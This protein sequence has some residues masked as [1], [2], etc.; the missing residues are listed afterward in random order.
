MFKALSQGFGLA[1]A[2]IVLKLFL[3]E[4]FVGVLELTT[5]VIDVLIR[6]VDQ[7]ATNLP[8]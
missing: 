8:A 6:A 7:A 2:I 1:I 3:P 4:V 5:K